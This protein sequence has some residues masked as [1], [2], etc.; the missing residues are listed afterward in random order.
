MNAKPDFGVERVLEPPQSVPAAAWRIDNSVAIRASE[1]RVRV[2]AI[3]PEDAGFKQLCSECAY[4]EIKIKERIFDI[5]KK[6]GKLHNPAT[7]SGGI[8]YGVVDAVGADY[9]KRALFKPGDEVICLTS[10]AAVP[11]RL[12]RIDSID[13]GY[14]QLACDGSAILSNANPLMHRPADLATPC[15]MAAI[16]EAGSL[17]SVFRMAAAPDMRRFLILSGDL[18]SAF[19]YAAVIRRATRG[20][21]IVVAL[22][23]SSVE[24]LPAHDIER[25]L[26]AY[27]DAVH[28]LDILAPLKSFDEIYETEKE[29]F[30]FSI[31]CADLMG[32][33]TVSV[34]LTKQRGTVSFTSFINNQ[35]LALLFSESIGRE[36]NISALDA[37]TEDYRQFTV[38]LLRAAKDELAQIH[39]IYE[40]RAAADRTERTAAPAAQYRDAERVGDLVFASER[41]KRLTDEVLNIA[42][43]DCN[44][45]ILGETGV[46][47]EKILGLLY[48]NS[49]RKLNPCVRINC[50]AI[51]ENLAESEFFGYEAG[52][53]TGSSPGGKRGYFELANN[54]I[55]FL[56]EVGLLPAGIQV[57]LLRVLQENQ[58]FRIGGQ[59]Q[60]EVNVRVICANNESLHALV[61]SGRFREDLYY[62]LN[63]CE[64]RIPPL[65][66]RP[67]DIAVLATHFLARYNEA[68]R[69]QKRFAPSGTDVMLAYEWPGNVRE[70]ENA[71]H[72]LVIGSKGDRM[73]AEDVRR[74]LHR[75]PSGGEDAQNDRASC[76]MDGG[77]AQT[78]TQYERAL[79]EDALKRCKSTRKAAARLGISQSQLMRKKRKYNIITE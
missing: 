18:L 36:L 44:V 22:D 57:K 60:I 66:E 63:I 33:E 52:A 79:I 42:K 11:L 64:I 23:K 6:R 13:F 59:K 62:R 10:L 78:V 74:A 31:N 34:L 12:D 24:R 39:D 53:F 40:K 68:Y 46:G 5:V 17:H 7:G 61:E 71:V 54:G 20:G 37:Y 51:P 25:V 55:L 43:Y 47:K 45:L 28:I 26:G 8:F 19:L 38:D 29:L 41:M 69:L 30:D 3:R 77:L 58:F 72:R 1:L 73:E 49:E 9:E 27:A 48:K 2:R 16:E 21:Y 75:H 67:E 15:T 76:A 14:G 56:D 50:A 70:L 32:T 4:D 35:R 65:R